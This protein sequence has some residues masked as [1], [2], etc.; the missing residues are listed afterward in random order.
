MNAR[1]DRR[2]VWLGIAVAALVVA[3]L[4]W[5]GLGGGF[6]FDDISNLVNNADLRVKTLHLSD[7]MA[8][9]FSSPASSLQR[10]LSMATFALNHYFTGMDPSAMKLTN[11]GIHLVNTVLTFQ[12]VRTLLRFS[13]GV[14]N[15]RVLWASLFVSFAWAAH[16]INLMAVLYV[17]QR[18]ESLCDSFVLLGLC[19]Y[20]ST[21]IRQM[22]RG[23]GWWQL[24]LGLVACTALGLLAKESAV[25]LPVYAFFLELCLFRFRGVEARASRRL[26]QMYAVLLFAPAL[27]AA[28]VVLPQVLQAGAYGSRTFTLGTR[29]LTELRVVADYLHWSVVPDLDAMSLYHDDYLVSKSLFDP[30]STLF[31]GLGLAVLLAAAWHWRRVRPVASLGVF[32]FFSAQ[33]LTAT[34]IPLELMFEHRNYFAS[35]GV[36]LVLGDLLLLWPREGRLR[37]AGNL[38]AVLLLAL[39]CLQTRLRALEWS[40]PVR[41]ALT[42]VRKHPDSPRATYDLARILVMLSG[43]KAD[44]RYLQPAMEAIE[45]A[46]HAPGASLLPAQAALILSA[47]TGKPLKQEWWLEMQGALRSRPVGPEQIGALA[48]L[49]HCA[50]LHM[51]DFPPD[52]MLGVFA[53]ALSHGD[54][55]EVLKIYGDYVLNSLGDAKLAVSLW[56]EAVRLRPSEPQYAINLGRLYVATGQP[57]EARREIARLRSLGHVG[58]NESA[59]LQLE[60]LLRDNKGPPGPPSPDP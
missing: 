32:W 41:F 15:R 22:Q 28:A 11:L 33:L 1:T 6:V 27:A 46:R 5:P 47:R 55:A 53:A 34:V 12:L 45:K 21:R 8:A 25:L 50:N 51:C 20:A 30:S 36:C 37:L 16:P 58:Q 52:E 42:E 26:W 3:F 17:V 24:V 10:P 38:G 60:A 7:W 9:I 43:Y 56:K 39:F 35:L 31:C 14:E 49:G 59:A 44:S 18:M 2:M 13:E 54:N 29:L 48:A 57:V 19:V 23:G 4:Y 40:T